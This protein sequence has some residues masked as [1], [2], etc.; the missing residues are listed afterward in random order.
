MSDPT[1]EPTGAPATA[2]QLLQQGLFH[3][4]RGELSEAMDRYT[5]VLRADPN[6]AD[7]L[8]YV[9]VVACQEG[10][11]KEGIGLARRALEHAPPQARV[12]NLLG[13][14]LEAQGEHLEAVKSFDAAIALDANFAEAHGNR[15]NILAAAGMPAEALKGFERALALDPQA[16]PDWINRG[17]LLQELGRHADALE[18][19]DKAL[20][21]VPDHPS[22]L[23]N[24]A[25]AL[26]ML[27]RYAEAE[28]AYNAVIRRNPKL[29]VAQLQKGL[30]VKHQ[31]RLAEARLLIEQAHAL[32]RDDPETTFALSLIML[33]MGDWRAAWPLFEA[34][35]KLARPAYEPLEH[36]RWM[37]AR[38]GD[39]RLV[40]LAEQ[41]LGDTLQF[42]RYASLLAGRGHAVTL[43][44]PPVLSPLLRSM[45]GIERVISTD[46]ELANDR[47]RVEWLPLMSLMGALHLTADA[48]PAQEPY[49]AAPP[50][51]V[52]HWK[53][54]LG[55]GFKAG[56]FWRGS[57]GPSAA[58]LSALAPL[59]EVTGV[60][61]ISLQ[62]G[63]AAGEI[64]HV[65]FAARIETP[66]DPNDLS[67]EAFVDTAAVMANLD[68]VVSVDSMPA[69]L[70]GALGRPVLL[71]L[72]FV[73]DWRW[74]TERD[75]TPWYPATRLF[76]QDAA[77]DWN[78]VFARI[79]EEVRHRVK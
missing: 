38:P 24:R 26:A 58:P 71:A 14:A 18:S 51:R 31:G 61:L 79:A 64:A 70:A 66:L 16:A 78:A 21:L 46:E 76:R 42:A 75:D 25:N 6:N 40:I 32:K 3:H 4:Q 30:A 48:V 15:A 49:L 33:L 56:L 45:P 13:K 69:H 2:A 11:F 7:A 20:A 77:R 17:A 22:V 37:G 63:E 5:A 52:A 28:A 50:E 74:L 68:A 59:A 65:P 43:F 47:R 34:R 8:Y 60:R 29:Q 62:K 44:A 27:G 39:Y 9:A 41:G 23:F 72:P 10:Q 73:P 55:D 1:S 36:P 54:R 12:H 57:T 67:A 19:Y 53:A 35:A